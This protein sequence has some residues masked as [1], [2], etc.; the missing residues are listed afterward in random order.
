MTKKRSLGWT[1]AAFAVA[2]LAAGAAQAVLVKG[3]GE[4][5][6]RGSG[7]AVLELRGGVT[8]SGAG[9]AVVEEAAIVETSGEGRMTPLGDGRVLLE[10]FG[11]VSVRSLEDPTHVELAGARLRIRAR[12]AGFAWLRGVGQYTTEDAEGRW[13]PTLAIELEEGGPR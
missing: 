10:G 5:L 12:G 9:L 1:G 3:R 6:A 2:C 13:S 11:Q 7:F 4:L 8:A